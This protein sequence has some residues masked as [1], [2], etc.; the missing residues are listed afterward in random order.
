MITTKP[1]FYLEI[2]H[3]TDSSACLSLASCFLPWHDAQTQKSDSD[4]LPDMGK[5]HSSALQACKHL[6]LTQ[7]LPK[8]HE[9]M[10]KKRSSSYVHKLTPKTEVTN[11]PTYLIMPT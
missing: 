1:R 5:Q 7:I 4:F 9:K 3:Y 11:K 2:N 8:T 6:D 10:R